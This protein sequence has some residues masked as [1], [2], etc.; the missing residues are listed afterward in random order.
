M[1]ILSSI[2]AVLVPF[3]LVGILGLICKAYWLLFMFGWGLL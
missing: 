3:V 1:S 2:A